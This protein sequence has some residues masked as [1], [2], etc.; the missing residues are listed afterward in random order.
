MTLE[1]CLNEQYKKDNYIIRKNASKNGLAYIYCS[2]NDLYKK[3][4]LTSFTTRVVNNDR[5]EWV[6]I[7]AKNKPE[8]E[9]FIRDIWLSWYVKG[10]NTS[11]DT[12]EKLISFL[13]DITVGYT[14]RCVGVSSGGFIGSIIAMELSAEL[15][16]SFAGQ[17]SLTH[18]FDHVIKNPFLCEHFKCWGGYWVDYYKRIPDC[19]TTIIYLYP[20][21]SN[22]DTEQYNLVKDM[23]RV[24]TIK[25]D[26]AEHGI[27]IYPFAIPAYLSLPF[28]SLEKMAEKT[29]VS[30][31]KTSIRVGGIVKFAQWGIRKIINKLR[32]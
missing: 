6:N 25:V 2:S 27:A 26:C 17:F 32:H 23:A 9:I 1:E 16:Y 10:I 24:L 3:D 19:L 21:G 22:Q 31:I 29:S 14:V 5:Y 28:S 8:L 7:S 20:T 30:K 13:K 4:D 18:H 15:C 11:I 12:Y